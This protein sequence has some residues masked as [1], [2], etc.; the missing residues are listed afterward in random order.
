M[1]AE[2]MRIVLASPREPS[3]GSWLINCLLELGVRVNLKTAIDRV[4][5]S[6]NNMREPAAMWEPADNG[7][8]RLHPRA[9]SLKKWLPILSTRETLRFR[10][11]VSVF[12]VQ[13]L[14]RPEVQGA[15]SVLFV[16]DPR[17]AIQSFYQRV[18]PDQ[19]LQT[20][21]H[22]PHPETLLDAI[23]HWRL[24]V[25]SWMA[26]ENIHV[27]RFEDYKSDA[28]ALLTR[29][30]ADLGIRATSDEI[31]HAAH[32]SSYE[33]AR[34]A[35]ERYRAQHPGD[36]EVAI[37]AG[38]VGEW[39]SSPELAELSR[40]IEIRTSSVLER[41]G[42]KLHLPPSPPPIVDGLSQLRFLPVFAQMELPASWREAAAAGD[43]MQC[44]H[45][46]PTLGHA[47]TLDSRAIAAARL[48]TR[49]ARQL[50]DSLCE[51][52]SAWQQLQRSRVESL[53][54]EFDN[55][56][57]FQM[58]RIRELARQMRAKRAQAVAAQASSTL[59]TR[60]TEATR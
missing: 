37:R 59:E 21:V 34:A 49:E 13:D 47:S 45:L 8:W 3:G 18:K 31:A 24:F 40:E 16:R 23:A 43:P 15:H 58:N 42:Y 9:E 11:D 5:R 25:E 7:E 29:I 46:L 38:K 44:P 10:E 36:E 53:R 60:D 54:A 28:V 51:Y 32:A 17:D 4:F 12:Y 1:A 14:P 20:F 48:H 22:F 52:A 56:S 50:L 57:D 19:T 41:L 39:K 30:V 27:Y 2:P 33:K 6:V 35:E 26:R 55:G